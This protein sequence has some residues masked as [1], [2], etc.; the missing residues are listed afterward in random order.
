MTT[1]AIIGMQWGDEGKGK[2]IDLFSKN[3]LHVVRAQGGHNAGHTLVV[4][5][6]EYRF[7]LVP[8]G[9]LY[10]QV[11]C[12]IGGGTVVEPRSLLKE[13]DGLG[14]DVRGRLFLSPYAHLILPHHP[15]RDRE[16][17]EQ[18]G[19]GAVGTTGRGIGPA[20]SD[21]VNRC[22]LRV[23]DLLDGARLGEI[24]ERHGQEFADYAERLAPYVAPVEEMLYEASK[25]GEKILCEGAQGTFLDVT[26]GTY[27]FVTSSCTLAGGISAGAGIGPSRIDRV[28]GVAKAYTTRVGNGPLPTELD[29]AEMAL[30][31]DHHKAREIGTSTGR[32]RRMGWPDLV[33]LKRAVCLNGADS[34][35]IMKLDILDHL[36]TIKVCTAYRIDGKDVAFFP[37]NHWEK[38]E[39]VYEELPGWGVSTSE[40]RSFE[41][42]PRQAQSYLR[43]LEE[44]LGVPMEIISVGPERHQTIWI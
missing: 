13:I 34:L 35:A 14:R 29:G 8:S 30:F 9:I 16:S 5:G 40:I 11:K 3:A 17:E 32:K 23:A 36:E 39:P 18:K 6:Q 7:H 41:T 21:K 27:P 24:I 42:L 12:Y 4:D 31:P 26:F 37:A 44:R 33:L 38:I 20:Y 19:S 43:F 25:R 28:V 1:L 22:G 2:V 10:P 15:L